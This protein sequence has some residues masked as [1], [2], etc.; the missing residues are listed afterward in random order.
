MYV[1]VCEGCVMFCFCLSQT[2]I[3]F[4]SSLRY[5]PHPHRHSKMVEYIGPAVLYRISKFIIICGFLW[6]ISTVLLFSFNA[7]SCVSH[8]HGVHGMEKYI[9]LH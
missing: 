7:H 1:F 5:F 2:T 6:A 4:T 8:Y 9:T 3:V